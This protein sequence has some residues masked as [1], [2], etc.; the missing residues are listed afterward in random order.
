MEIGEVIRGVE[1]G[2]R[3]PHPPPW[4]GVTLFKSVGNAVQDLAVASLALERAEALEL[5]TVV[6]G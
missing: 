3:V 6:R 1:E 2:G 4:P 5:G